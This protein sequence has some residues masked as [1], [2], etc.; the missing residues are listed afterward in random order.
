MIKVQG[1]TLGHLIETLI[2]TIG[3]VII[4]LLWLFK[5]L[6]IDPKVNKWATGVIFSTIVLVSGLSIISWATLN[7]VPPNVTQ[8]SGESG[9]AEDGPPVLPPVFGEKSVREELKRHLCSQQNKL[10]SSIT[11][12]F[13]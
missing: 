9:D 4:L 10:N 13:E 2:L 11:C 1:F 5:P 3:A 7:N 6:F 8:S 12:F